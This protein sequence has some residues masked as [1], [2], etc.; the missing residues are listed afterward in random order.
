MTLRN[1]SQP[2]MHQGHITS[3]TISTLRRGTRGSVKILLLQ[4]RRAWGPD[5]SRPTVDPCLTA[6]RPCDDPAPCNSGRRPHDDRL[7]AGPNA[8]SSPHRS[9]YAT[10]PP[11]RKNQSEPDRN[12]STYTYKEKKPLK[13]RKK[14]TDRKRG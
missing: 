9:T 7:T 1:F 12:N 5:P 4:A 2:M 8:P 11:Q 10:S 14:D 13:N 3:D 6:G